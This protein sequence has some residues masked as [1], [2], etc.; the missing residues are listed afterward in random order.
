MALAEDEVQQ[1]L[2]SLHQSVRALRVLR[3]QQRRA[4]QHSNEARV[5]RPRG[6]QHGRQGSQV[7]GG[8]DAENLIA[9]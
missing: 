1:K 2:T 5:A 3:A 8:G 6:G 4:L 9:S 7:G